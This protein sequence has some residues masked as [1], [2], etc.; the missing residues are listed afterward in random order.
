MVKWILCFIKEL[1]KS[2]ENYIVDLTKRAD[3]YNNREMVKR[4]LLKG[5]TVIEIAE[6]T[7]MTLDEVLSHT[8]YWMGEIPYE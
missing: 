3:S 4:Y 1:I 6:M 8:R 7:P 2:L 5:Y